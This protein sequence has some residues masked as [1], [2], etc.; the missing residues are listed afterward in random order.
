MTDAASSN[1]RAKRHPRPFYVKRRGRWFVQFGTKQINLGPDEA[2]AFAKYF[3]LIE[4]RGVLTGEMTVDGVIELFLEHTKMTRAPTTY[5]VYS[6]Y[7]TRFSRF[8]NREFPKLTMAGLK[9]IHLTKFQYSLA[10]KTY[11]HN[12]LHSIIRTTKTCFNWAAG[13]GLIVV[14]PVAKAEM[15]LKTAREVVVTEQ[16]WAIVMQHAQGESFRD[17]LTLYRESGARPGEIMALEARNIDPRQQAAILDRVSSKGK[18]CKRVIYFTD[19]AWPIVLKWCEKHPTGAILRNEAGKRWTNSA[20]NCRL[21]RMKKHIGF[22]LMPY[23]LRHTFATECLVNG[24][25][26]VTVAELM[27]H[28]D[29]TM[30][31]KVFGHLARQHRYLR[32]QLNRGVGRNLTEGGEDGPADEPMASDQRP[33]L[34]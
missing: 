6:E 13:Q 34:Q 18:K 20:V 15:P 28:R 26:A 30:V 32:E 9:C 21:L 12:T 25:D 23:A 17:L 27:G 10:D 2:Q 22:K 24:V 29:L 8:L 4:N 3:K 14:S 7:L 33:E 16:Q 1:G 11:S 5:D 31:A 19:T